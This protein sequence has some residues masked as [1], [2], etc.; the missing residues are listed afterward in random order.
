MADEKIGIKRAVELVGEV[1]LEQKTAEQLSLL[2]TPAAVEL[3]GEDDAAAARSGRGRPHGSLN[4]RTKEWTDFILSRYTSPLLFL[5]ETYTRPVQLL[6]AELGCSIEDAFKI[7]MVAAKE[8]GPYVH[9]RQAV[10]VQ[11][12]A[13]VV[14]LNL[15]DLATIQAAGPG[16]AEE[17]AI[18]IE[19]TVKT[20]AD[21][22][23]PDQ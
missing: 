17:G 23:E 14:S 15:V 12:D 4:R 8:L 11:L 6:A 9:Q 19:A 16:D 10:A 5:A 21:E 1:A 7:Q 22:S 3:A 2:P 18:T 20:I 13:N